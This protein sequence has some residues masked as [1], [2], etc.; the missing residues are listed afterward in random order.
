M[1]CIC[2]ETPVVTFCLPLSN[3][4]TNKEITK[5]RT[6]LAYLIGHSILRLSHYRADLHLY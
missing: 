3:I 2:E 4:F 1:V 5:L 6:V